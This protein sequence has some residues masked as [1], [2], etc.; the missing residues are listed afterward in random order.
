MG[1]QREHPVLG[2]KVSKVSRMGFSIVS[3]L[4]A[5]AARI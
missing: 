3:E 2:S 4:L 1:V 5:G